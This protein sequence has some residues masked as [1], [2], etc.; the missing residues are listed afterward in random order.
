MESFTLNLNREKLLDL[1]EDFYILTSVK[2]ALFDINGNEILSYPNHHCSFCN[3]VRST[4]EGEKLCR[5][6]NENSFARCQK[7]RTLEI[8]KCHAGLIETTAPLIDQG[9][10]IGYIMFG[11]ITDILDRN[12]ITDILKDTI[13]KLNLDSVGYDASIYNVAVK[14]HEQI[15]AAAKIL[16]ACTFYVLFH[17]LVSAQRDTFAQNLNQFLIAHISEDLSVDRLTKE[18]NISKNKL[19]ETCNRHLSVGIAEYIK[20]IRI[21]EAKKLLKETELP[22]YII[23][24]L[25]GFNDYNYFCRVF[26]KETGISARKYRI[27]H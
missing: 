13:Q 7:K 24:D 2:I 23:S 18:F 25:V 5:K 22:I 21:N 1:M 8:F 12:C 19:Y 20:S 16:E 3:L 15:E 9:Q 27:S 26:K 14:T 17:D 6:S 11:Q 4:K 10:V